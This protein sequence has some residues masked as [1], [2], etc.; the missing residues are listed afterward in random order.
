MTSI[1]NI[2]QNSAASSNCI[3]SFFIGLILFR[4][5]FLTDRGTQKY[6]I[7]YLFQIIK[8]F[9]KYRQFKKC[10][11]GNKLCSQL[12]ISKYNFYL[13]LFAIICTLQMHDLGR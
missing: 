8:D 10:P 5:D 12:L 6:K 7:Y 9:Q 11:G 13:Q 1:F 3:R 4:E 2:I